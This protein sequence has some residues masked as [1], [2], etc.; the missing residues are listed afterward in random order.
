MSSHIAT[1]SMM[2][3][4]ETHTEAAHGPE[5]AVSHSAQSDASHDARVESSA[6][7]AHTSVAAAHDQ[8]V[9]VFRDAEHQ[10]GWD[11]SRSSGALG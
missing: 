10:T 7:L 8:H 9:G 11:Q 6:R 1:T 5:D 4:H 2:D 3:A